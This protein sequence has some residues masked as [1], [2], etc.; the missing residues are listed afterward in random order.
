MLVAKQASGEPVTIESRQAQV[1]RPL[2][3]VKPMT[4]QGQW[5]CFGPDKAFAYKIDTGRVIPSEP[6]PTGWDLML[7]LEAPN[8]ANNMLNTMMEVAASE[9]RVNRGLATAAAT[10]LP[11]KV[12]QLISGVSDDSEIVQ[13]QPCP[14]FG[15]RGA[16][17]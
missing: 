8:D 4:E 15:W 5:V 1:R 2:M 14:L 11:A 6:M 12:A 10:G 7:E 3:A 16:S 17:P 9:R 13:R